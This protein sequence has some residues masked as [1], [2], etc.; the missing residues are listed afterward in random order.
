[1]T[2]YFK[3]SACQKIV[4]TATMTAYGNA[5][6]TESYGAAFDGLLVKTS[7]GE[8]TVGAKSGQES[9]TYNLFVPIGVELVKD[10]KLRYTYIDGRSVFLRLT[11]NAII[12]D[13]RS[14]QTDWKTYTAAT[15]TPTD[16][17]TENANDGE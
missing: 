10:D 16:S 3:K 17:L 6:I 9:N 8:K 4:P 15:Y 5:K 12:N 2:D 7:T 14:G 1:M 13:E 11:S